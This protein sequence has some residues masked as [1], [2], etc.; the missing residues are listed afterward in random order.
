M[1]LF[2]KDAVV[3]RLC[4]CRRCGPYTEL[5]YSIEGSRTFWLVGCQ[6]CAEA[7]RKALQATHAPT[8]S[9]V[10]NT[11]SFV[12]VRAYLIKKKHQEGSLMSCKEMLQ[13]KTDALPSQ[14]TLFGYCDIRRFLGRVPDLFSSG[15]S[16]TFYSKQF[17][18][19]SENFFND[20]LPYKSSF[21]I[22]T[23]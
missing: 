12:D 14:V 11:M 16:L 21:L 6:V 10:W 23:S 3:R 22:H 20:F 13:K 15:I 9:V 1:H 4:V 5:G 17:D 7:S 19:N 2:Q 18:Q 8:L